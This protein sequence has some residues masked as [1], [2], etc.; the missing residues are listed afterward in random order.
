MKS[1]VALVSLLFAFL[2][3]Q[4]YARTERLSD[5]I[6]IGKVDC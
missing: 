4:G 5:S 2:L 6:H 1:A 3:V